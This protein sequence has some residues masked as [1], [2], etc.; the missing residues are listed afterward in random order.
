MEKEIAER[1]TQT[2]GLKKLL[3]ASKN[4]N[5]L[6]T[7]ITE[8]QIEIAKVENWNYALQQQLEEAKSTL[9]QAEAKINE[10]IKDKKDLVKDKK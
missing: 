6:E 4:L 10:L 1:L 7:Q 9:V 8:G 3:D 2:D 5:D